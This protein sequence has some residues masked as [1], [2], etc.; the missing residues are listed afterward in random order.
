M[1]WRG[2]Q[3]GW[4]VRRQLEA[5][6][7][8]AAVPPAAAPTACTAATYA[9][10]CCRTAVQPLSL[11][12]HNAMNE[13]AFGGRTSNHHQPHAAAAAW[14]AAHLGPHS[15]PYQPQPLLLCRNVC[16]CCCCCGLGSTCGGACCCCCLLHLCPVTQQAGDL[17]AEGGQR[18]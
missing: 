8:A 7:Q 15:W 1:P 13:P 16:C 2:P 18:G 14:P 5:G 10:E 11:S 4:Q 17:L 9:Y 6:G 12:T 3:G